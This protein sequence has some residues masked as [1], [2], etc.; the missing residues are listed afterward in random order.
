M[1]FL[2]KLRNLIG[3]NKTKVKQGI[4]KASDTV[5]SKVGA[6]HADKVE[7]VAEK[8]KDVVDKLPE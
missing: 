4:D 2:D 6:K 5:E 1:G 3:G 7:N 8:A